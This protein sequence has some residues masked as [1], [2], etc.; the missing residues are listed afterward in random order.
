M[1][2]EDAL[3][4]KGIVAYNKREFFDAHEYWEELWLDYQLNDAKFIQGLIQIAVSYFHFFN[5]NLNGARSMIKKS[6]NNLNGF[7]LERGIDVIK[8]KSDVQRISNHFNNIEQTSD[9]IDS[10]IIILKVIDG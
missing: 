6:L 4:K 1:K 7:I 10:Y 3:F 9:N 2:K 5:Q 8:L